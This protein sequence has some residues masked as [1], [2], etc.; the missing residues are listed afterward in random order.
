MKKEEVIYMKG[1]KKVIAVVLMALMVIGVSACSKSGGE[2]GDSDNS[3]ES[4]SKSYDKIVYAYATFNTIPDPDTLDTVEEAINKIT[5]EKIGVEV[6]L[7]PIA[8]ADY[9]SGV[10]LA[11]QG[12]D[13]IDVF[14]S[15][16]D[17]N[18]STSNSMAYELTDLIDTLA[19]E[20]KALLSEDIL[21]ACEKDG[22]LYGIPAY[23]PYAI[24]P[25]VI[26]KQDIA[27]ELGIDMTQVK[28]IF[29]LTDVLRKVKVAY[30][31]IS[32]L[33]P[34]QQGTSGVNLCNQEVDFLTDDFYSPK[35]VLKGNDMTVVDYY[36]TDEFAKVCD[37]T[38]TWYNEGLIL[39]DAATTT[40]TA[41][42]LMSADNSF[43]YVASY[44][45][46][47]ADTAASLEAQVGGG[48]SLGAVQIGEAYL[49]T[50][51]INALS[52]MVSSTSKVPEAALK[53]LNMTFTDKDIINLII[54][55][56]QDRDYVMDADGYVSY[57]E[58]KDASSVPYTAQLSCGT[59]GN[60]FLMHPMVGT[61]KD[62]LV[63]EEEQ[64][65]A[66]KKSPAMGF[67]FDGSSVK[68]EYTVISNVIQQ[69]LPGL[70]CGSV[71]PKIVLPEFKEKLSS[72]G[73][74]AIIAAKQEQ[75][76][77]WL[78]DKQ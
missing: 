2:K 40:S 19:P 28:S 54:Y 3:S 4:A 11:L 46:P 33:I 10:S 67:T 45:Y 50:T 51:T 23:K 25:M 14:E 65:R 29:D 37:L 24:T 69:Y 8:I 71:D 18:T 73:L 1:I 76:D 13:K 58:G 6:E 26:Y 21:A 9:S 57:P 20:T 49:D 53:F 59:L 43:C 30:P 62:S 55:G 74:D 70:L 60:Y 52:W 42:E 47:T 32:P 15:I 12:G 48:V 5:R 77:K 34:V 22:K 66:A 36:S 72:A 68:T 39:Q 56:I 17:F 44:S 78:A 63:W 31:D 35:G 61:S 41:S 38:R 75:L 27:D 7:K 64:N 16:G